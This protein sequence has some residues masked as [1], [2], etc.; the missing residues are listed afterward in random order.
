MTKAWTCAKNKKDNSFSNLR[1]KWL[2]DNA[3]RLLHK[4]SPKLFPKL[5]KKF[6]M[7]LY[8]KLSRT[9]SKAVAIVKRPI[10]SL[11]SPETCIDFYVDFQ[12]FF[13]ILLEEQE[14]IP[15][16]AIKHS[17]AVKKHFNF[18]MTHWKWISNILQHTLNFIRDKCSKYSFFF[19]PSA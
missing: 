8:R 2:D 1:N 18:T 10:N 9:C 17:G 3:C 14:A 12:R 19:N 13:S 11:E 15:R 4:L 7:Y 5:S 16:T 6:A